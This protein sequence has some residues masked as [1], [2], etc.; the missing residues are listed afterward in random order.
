MY[1]AEAE[2]NDGLRCDGRWHV[3][4][5]SNKEAQDMIA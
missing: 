4:V 2:W 1:R 3:S 5:A